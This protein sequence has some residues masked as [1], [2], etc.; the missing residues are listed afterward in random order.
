MIDTR[1]ETILNIIDHHYRESADKQ[2]KSSDAA[3]HMYYEG[4][5]VALHHMRAFIKEL[6]AI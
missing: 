2:R 3:Q 5:M 6:S 1:T 4:K